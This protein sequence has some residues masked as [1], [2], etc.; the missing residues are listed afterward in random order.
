VETFADSAFIAVHGAAWLRSR[1]T[2]R[3]AGTKVH[4]VSGDVA[5]PGVYEYPFGVSVQQILD[6]CGA[7]DTAAVQV[8][9]P[10][11]TLLARNEFHRRVA[12]EDVPSAG[13][14]MV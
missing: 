2:A 14:F 11:G 13:A 1:G 10:S 12:F 5:R 9:G 4:S 3:S 6:D 7:A 8:G